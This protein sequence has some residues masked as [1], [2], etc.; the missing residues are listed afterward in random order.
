MSNVTFSSG[1]YF[2]G[3][4]YIVN[5]CLL[6]FFLFYILHK[7]HKWWDTEQRNHGVSQKPSNYHHSFHLLGENVST[8]LLNLV[9][10]F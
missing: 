4:P 9:N 3:Q 6:L 1:V 5:K 10:K 8:V 2:L 7:F